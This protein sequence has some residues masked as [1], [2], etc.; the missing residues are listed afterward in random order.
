M[1]ERADTSS[2]SSNSPTLQLTI[3]HRGK[4]VTFDLPHDGTITDLA[5]RI[6]EVLSIP[7]AN[8]KFMVTPKV[9]MLKPPFQESPPSL[10]S[11]VAKK[12]V[13]MGSTVAEVAS[14][15]A[16]ASRA[17]SQL[18]KSTIPAA[19][20]AARARNSQQARDEAIY[21]FTTLRPLP[22]LPHPER[23]LA[24][25]ARLRDDP[26]IK[27]T[28]RSHRWTV[29]VLTEMNPAE[30]TTHDSRTL[31]L[32]RNR[33][34]VIELR[35]RT[36]AYDGYRDYKTIRKTLCH[37][38]A[39]N[40]HGEHDGD[41]WKLCREVEKE[42]DRADWTSKGRA[43]TDQEFYDPAGEI[44]MDHGGWTGGEYI[45]GASES[46][47]SSSDRSSA[48]SRREVL[49]RAAEE[50]MRQQQRKAGE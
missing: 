32:N 15:D 40:V 18:R 41:F 29:P 31:G 24:F 33:G 37:E 21:T 46:N 5:E 6:E 11:L 23:S 7:A 28:M 50:R 10:Q 4:P 30:H 16:A 12:I 22:Y 13:L 49:A 27:A 38:L 1:A 19:S 26:G 14:V 48:M 3:H 42:V 45:L 34:E 43:L 20:P 39:H 25:L 17:T 2:T 47:N 44:H 9:G 35:L 36:D 8:Q